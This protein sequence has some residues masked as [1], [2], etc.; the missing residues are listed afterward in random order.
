MWKQPRQ[1]FTENFDAAAI[2]RY[3]CVYLKPC[4][5]YT[6]RE[7]ALVSTVLGSCVS[8]SMFWPEEGAGCICH[9]MLPVCDTDPDCSS[10]H[11][12][13]FVD[14]SIHCMHK[15]LHEWG[16]SV[17]DI[18]VKIFGGADMFGDQSADPSVLDS[19][20]RKNIRSAFDTV[21]K[22]GYTVAAQDVGGKQGRKLYFYSSQGR[23]LVKLLRNTRTW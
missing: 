8:V 14:S 1:R 16:A 13:K 7:P 12:S 9:A 19:I 11:Y 21:A 5:I 2:G 4:D 18:E 17:R 20:G 23:V 22:L 6:G 3:R 10:G 15:K